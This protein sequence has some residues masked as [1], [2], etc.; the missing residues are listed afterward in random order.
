MKKKNLYL[1]TFSS[2]QVRM[3]SFSL[4]PSVDS[5]FNYLFIC[6]YIIYINK[7]ETHTNSSDDFDAKVGR[8]FTHVT[9]F[10]HFTGDL[11]IGMGRMKWI[12]TVGIAPVPSCAFVT[13]DTP[14]HCE[15]R[16]F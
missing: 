7:Q 4:V 5:Y 11:V 10:G 16:V 1:F 9:L 13:A 2:V 6:L 12:V 14:L 15:Q 3:T 8:E